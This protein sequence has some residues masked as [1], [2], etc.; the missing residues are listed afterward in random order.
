MRLGNVGAAWAALLAGGTHHI[1]VAGHNPEVQRRGGA[2]LGV[3][4]EAQL[5]EKLAAAG[6][7]EMW[8]WGG[9]R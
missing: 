8:E 3:L 1:G 9:R 2:L 7:Q 6:G 5:G 4:V